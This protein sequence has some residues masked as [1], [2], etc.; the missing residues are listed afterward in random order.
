MTYG[1]SSKMSIKSKFKRR[2]K[3]SARGSETSITTKDDMDNSI[4]S[5]D[6]LVIVDTRG[7]EFELSVKG[8]WVKTA[9]A[10]V[11]ENITDI[12]DNA[13]DTTILRTSHIGSTVLS[14]TGDGSQLTNMPPGWSYASTLK[15]S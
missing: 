6:D 1:W 9:N 2:L 3:T 15:F 12:A 10:G 5:N 4:A 7:Q 13:T 11:Q 14:P 8:V